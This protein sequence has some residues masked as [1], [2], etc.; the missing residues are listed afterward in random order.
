M[1]MPSPRRQ[2]GVTLI[3]VL[4]SIV[5]L[6]FGL[7]GIAVFQSKATVGA[8]ESYQ[9]AQAVILLEDMSARLQ[10]NPAQADAYITASAGTG[11]GQSADCATLAIGAPRDLC[12]WSSALKG[13]A[14]TAADRSNVGAMIGARGCV[15]QVQAANPAA[16]ICTPAIYRVTVA[17]QG[18]HPTI[19]PSLTCGKDLYGEETGRRA[20]AIQVVAPLLDCS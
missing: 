20:I 2:Q 5:I 4:V 13:A 10:G 8:L 19:A 6:A 1:L 16:G 11:D 9:R 7:L 17:W 3:E 15:E 12:E 14:E 18:L